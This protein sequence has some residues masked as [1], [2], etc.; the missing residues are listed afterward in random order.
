MNNL[1]IN[2]QDRKVYL[3]KI[4][5]ATGDVDFV[6]KPELNSEIYKEKSNPDSY[7]INYFK[8]LGIK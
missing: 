2:L 4:A 6:I 3:I 8:C 5:A 1:P 7:F